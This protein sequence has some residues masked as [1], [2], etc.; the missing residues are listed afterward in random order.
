MVDDSE[1]VEQQ[2]RNLTVRRGQREEAVA[3][4]TARLKTV[5]QLAA[6][7]I[8]LHDAAEHLRLA[9]EEVLRIQ[10]I[11]SDVEAAEQ[12]VGD[13]VRKLEAAEEALK[14]AHLQN[15]EAAA[16]LESAE[17]AA[18][19]AGRDS[20]MTDTVAR[21]RLELRKV[22]ADQASREAQQRINDAT[23]AQKL[24]DA[25][26]SANGDHLVQQTEA[27][28][29]QAELADAVANE[30]STQA[31]LR[32]IDLLELALDARDADDRVSTGQ[33]DVDKIANLQA[34]LATEVGERT[35]LEELR[36][37]I[38]VPAADT[39]GPMRRL[40]NDIAGARGALSV[41][42]VVTVKPSR[43]IG[44]RAKKDGTAV[45]PAE[46]GE[47]L[48][49]EANAEIDIDI[50]DIANVHIRGGRRDAQQKVEAMEVRW[51]SEVEPHLRAANV[52]DLDGLSAKI[53]EAE[54]L[55][56]SLTAKHAELQSL[57]EEIDSLADSMQKLDEA[58]KRKKACSAA[59]GHISLET[60]LPDLAALGAEPSYTLRERRQYAA[61]DI[62][63][64]LAK[65]HQA[66]IAHS[67]A[68]ERTKNSASALNAAVVAR[69]AALVTFSEGVAAALSDA[70]AKLAGALDEQQKVAA[71][72]ASLESTLAA[73]NERVEAAIREA[74]AI[75]DQ[76][77][78]GLDGASAVRTNAITAHALQV[79]RLEELRRL[80][81]AED[82]AAAESK[83][84]SASDRKA[85]LPVPE[86]LVT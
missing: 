13:L 82:F 31:Q 46:P 71:E 34:R 49:V 67:L 77:Q 75:A 79:G 3:V 2:L 73:Q 21:Q 9:S 36:A 45:K 15:E 43:T 57:Q 11:S 50:G 14:V 37:A 32:A 65:V 48:E 72:L 7:A 56:A 59:L 41:G 66:G 55:D 26:A 18:R 47:T 78:A 62:E 76:A 8:A 53:A 10:K 74:R 25:V 16:S 68:E 23:S 51:R 44:I 42:L 4:E 24:I 20:S 61:K 39:L 58:L 1:S 35:A 80:R 64:A 27:E 19:S 63:E 85:A 40:G 29:A 28:K 22:A 86:R 30:I 81:E 38:V 5:E 6:Q 54:A 60:L 84:K 17:K 52:E 69:D 83:L 70:Q 33:A 12:T